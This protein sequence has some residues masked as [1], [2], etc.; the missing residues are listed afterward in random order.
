MAMKRVGVVGLAAL[1]ILAVLVAV[2]WQTTHPSALTVSRVRARCADHPHLHLRHPITVRGVVGFDDRS[3]PIGRPTRIGDICSP[4]PGSSTV[5]T[6]LA[7]YAHPP[8]L[9]L[10]EGIPYSQQILARGD[11]LCGP[12]PYMFTPALTNVSSVRR[13]GP[14]GIDWSS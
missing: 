4:I 10:A 12:T 8:N 11:L 9:R 5:L 1:V 2:L 13:V 6:C 3:S 14:F 7:M